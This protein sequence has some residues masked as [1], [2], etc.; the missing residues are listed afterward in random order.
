[1]KKAKVKITLGQG[2]NVPKYATPESSGCDLC[3]LE[4]KTLEPG[5]RYLFSTGISVSPISGYETQVRSRS[6]LAINH[7]VVVLHGIGTVDND[8]TGEVKVPLINHGVEPF[9]VTVGMKIAQLV[10]CQ[11]LQAHF[12]VVDALTETQRGSGGFGSSGL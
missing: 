6:G 12:V 5:E 9:T 11:V 4:E 8:Y 10:M 2:A 7:G 3:S 1:M